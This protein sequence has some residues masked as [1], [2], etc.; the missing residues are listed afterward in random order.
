MPEEQIVAGAKT[1]RGFIAD[2]PKYFLHGLLYSIISAVAVSIL[3]VLSTGFALVITPI[4][5]I[6]SD[7]VAWIVAV[8]LL[9][10]LLVISLLVAAIINTYLSV[11]FWRVS[12][13]MNWKSLI[14]HGGT[15]T[16]LLFIFG[17][18]A[19]ALDIV[20]QGNETAYLLMLVP[21]I[22]IYAV[23]Y[24]YTGRFVALGFGDVPPATNVSQAPA[25][26]LATCPSC[27]IDTLCRMQ[28]DEDTKVISCTNCGL[29]FEVSRRK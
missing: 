18:P 24:G 5:T 10:F 1:E 7:I 2:L 19:F 17:L 11:T 15:F 27:G 23:V 3:D 13:P 22:V 4:A 21:R 9:F 12:S 20:F 14:G 28:D 26:L 25:G 8:V 16:V 29:P 6:G